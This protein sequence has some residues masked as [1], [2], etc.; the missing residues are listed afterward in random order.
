MDL[1]D[2]AEPEHDHP[3]ASASA[4]E[5]PATVVAVV[6]PTA[7]GK[8]DLALDLATAFGGPDEAEILNAD[9]Y[10][11]YRGMDIGTAK[12]PV[13]ERRGIVHHQLDVLDVTAD[14]SVARF[15]AEARA[16]VARV[17]AS[18]KRVVVVGGSGLYVRALLDE[19]DFPGTDP[20]V[21]A[22]WEERGER[23]GARPLHDEL[24][25][26]DP[27]AAAAIEPRNLRRIVRALEVIE[28]TGRPYSATLP[29]QEYVRPAV[30]IGLDADR[31]ELDARV[32][33]RVERMW[34]E[35]LVAEV[36]AL[37]GP[38][39]GGLG[40]TAERAV[41]Y[42]Q[43]LAALRGEISQEQAKDDVVAATRRLARKQMGWFG[44]DPRVHWLQAGSRDVV[45]R[46]ME[47]VALADAGR[48]R[49]EDGPT[50]RSLGS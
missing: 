5:Q 46:A 23:E 35:G 32:A 50:R 31:G 43:V 36:A 7:V 10:Q 2:R 25:R 42:A 16:D 15:Q 24:A 14:A 29:R 28:L 18:G 17:L 44:R 11:L 12:V 47:L 39:L 6:G 48:L 27:Q 8:S 21:R 9:A 4:S 49:P 13:A 37:A 41:G 26:L 20:D 22:R 45:A 40:R 1:S 19:M 3:G 34:D 33:S 38:G 30:Q